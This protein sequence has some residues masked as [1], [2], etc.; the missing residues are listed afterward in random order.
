MAPAGLDGKHSALLFLGGFILRKLLAHVL[1]RTMGAFLLIAAL[2]A[3]YRW[4]SLNIMACSGVQDTLYLLLT[5]HGQVTHPVCH[6]CRQTVSYNA[7]EACPHY[8][9]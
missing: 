7:G 8:P 1:S 4:R 5:W 9:L 6:Q 2:S 3:M